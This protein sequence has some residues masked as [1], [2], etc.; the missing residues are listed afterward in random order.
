MNFKV[1]T[2]AKEGFPF[3]FGLAMPSAIC[4]ALGF[5]WIGGVLLALALFVAFFFR[6]PRRNFQPAPGQV[7][8]PADGKIVSIR[9]EQGQE[10]LS[11]F[12][13]VFNVHINRA[14]IGGKI[15]KIDY[16]PGK[17]LV[18]FD[19]RASSENE[20]NSITVEDGSKAV[21]FVQIAGLIARR[22]V[23]WKKEGQMLA[24]GERIG[25]IRFGSRVD[26][27]LPPGSGIR[28]RLG[29]KVKAGVTVIGELP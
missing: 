5:P 15:S 2:V 3:I 4:L 7:I 26:V 17:F 22:I 14:P 23:C 20:Q 11:I 29:D 13:S 19:E 1:M 6:D 28:V 12:L 10:V 21:R 27:F 18:A 8:S 24:A 9:Q 25:L 16:K